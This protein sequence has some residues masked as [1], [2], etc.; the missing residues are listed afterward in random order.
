MLLRKKQCSGLV[1]TE[2]RSRSVRCYTEVTE[3]VLLLLLLLL[4]PIS[5]FQV[6]CGHFSQKSPDV[7]FSTNLRH[8]DDTNKGALI[9]RK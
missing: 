8:N 7:T 2:T 3:V 4:L 6:L 5:Q 1:E 9:H